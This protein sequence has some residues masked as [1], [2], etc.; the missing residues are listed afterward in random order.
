M[1]MQCPKNNKRNILLWKKWK[2]NQNCKYKPKPQIL[3]PK[4]SPKILK[5][6][7]AMYVKS[8]ILQNLFSFKW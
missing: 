3:P 4:I 8:L 6:Y 7:E 2:P 1:E 5:F